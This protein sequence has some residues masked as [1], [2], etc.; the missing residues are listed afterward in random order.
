M[1]PSVVQL[2]QPSLEISDRFHTCC[3]GIIPSEG[4][5]VHQWNQ[6]CYFQKPFGNIH[7]RLFGGNGHEG[8]DRMNALMLLTD[9]MV[10]CEDKQ[11][12]HDR[13]ELK[14]IAPALFKWCKTKLGQPV[15]IYVSP[16]SI[17][18][19]FFRSGDIIVQMKFP[20]EKPRFSAYLEEQCRA[21]WP[22]TPVT[23]PE[24]RPAQVW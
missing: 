10:A 18:T 14:A 16:T 11:T 13:E 7:H 5:V 8:P 3:H 21:N 9:M 17:S 23:V 19:R 22:E 1:S 6:H 12:V 2:L 24:N 20:V 15:V 4:P